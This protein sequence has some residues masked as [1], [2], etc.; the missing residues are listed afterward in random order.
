MNVIMWRNSVGGA[1]ATVAEQAWHP[2]RWRFG[3]PGG[4]QAAGVSFWAAESCRLK[5][6]NPSD[7]VSRNRVGGPR[8]QVFFDFRGSKAFGIGVAGSC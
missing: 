2:L 3:V 8:P 7:F 1:T 5:A 6:R 4:G